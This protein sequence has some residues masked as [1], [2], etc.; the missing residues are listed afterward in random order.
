[1]WYILIHWG[2]SAVGGFICPGNLTKKEAFIATKKQLIL[3]I[4]YLKEKYPEDE[5]DKVKRLKAFLKCFK[6]PW[7]KT[8]RGD[9]VIAIQRIDFPLEAGFW[10]QDI[11]KQEYTCNI[12]PYQSL[13]GNTHRS[14]GNVV[15]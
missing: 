15:E 14:V 2:G 9:N 10:L 1:M 4:K 3:G 11:I 7:R 6:Y 13:D 5:Y 12:L 8:K